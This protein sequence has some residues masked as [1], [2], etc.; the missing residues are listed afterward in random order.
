MNLSWCDRLQP[1]RTNKKQTKLIARTCG[2]RVTYL[3]ERKGPPP[4]LPVLELS[5]SPDLGGGGEGNGRR[6]AAA[7]ARA[8]PASAGSRREREEGEGRR[9]L[10]HCRRPSS[11]LRR[12]WE[13]PRRIRWSRLPH[14]PANAAAST[15]P[16][17]WLV[18]YV[19]VGSPLLLSS[20]AP[21][22]RHHYL[23]EASKHSHI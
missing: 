20:T 6:G 3:G 22:V 18:K 14:P 23:Q 2:W 10:H 12:I 4:S 19:V 11:P 5:P 7:S 15:L 21:P 16:F 1:F 17:M 13:G 9:R 8:P